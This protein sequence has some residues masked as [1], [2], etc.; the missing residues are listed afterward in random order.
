MRTHFP[1]LNALKVF[2]VAGRKLSFSK[3]ADELC[4]TQSAVSKQ[5][6]LLEQYLEH[7]LFI[8]SSTGIELTDAGKL[9]LPAI[10]QALDNI[11]S[12][13]AHLQQ[14]LSAEQ[15]LNLNV[16]PSFSNLWLIPRLPA[17]REACPGVSLAIRSGDGIFRGHE[18]E[19]DI[20]IR[21]LPL[22]LSYEN[23]VLLTEEILLPVLHP[24]CAARLPIE[25]PEDLLKHPLLVHIT[26]PQLWHHFLESV[27][28]SS[29]ITPQFSNGFEHFFMSFEA[30][31]QQQGIALIPAFMAADALA[32][33]E[34]INPLGIQYRSGYGFYVLVQPHRHQSSQVHALLNW[35]Q[36][37]LNATHSLGSFG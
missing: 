6:Q 9:Y 17:L 5:I 22:S 37:S 12:A 11:Q 3:A 13:T 33:G 34:L 1:P 7:P 24:D 4:V 27:V 16:S 29:P 20:A 19:D 32:R 10:S 25:Q 18:S 35:L 23:S 26:R 15:T 21:F 30:A 8:R 28:E 14:Q 2:E 36:S 31:R